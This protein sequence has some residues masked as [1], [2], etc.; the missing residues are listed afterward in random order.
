MNRLEGVI[1]KGIG[2]FYTVAVGERSYVC[3]AR[4][5][6]RRDRITPAI[7][8]RVRILPPQGEEDGFI[9]EILPRA[10]LLVR[11]PVANITRLVVALSAQ[12][13]QPDYLLADRLIVAA[14][15]AE[16]AVTI[17]FNKLDLVAEPPGEVE[18]Y[19]GCFPVLCVSSRTGQGIEELKRHLA[20][21]I[22]CFA[23]QSGVGKSSLLNAVD[24]GCRE[25]GD[26]TRIERGRN[27]TR[28]AELIPLPGGGMVVDTAGFS[29][30]E[31]AL[32]PPEELME[33]YPELAPYVGECRFQGCLHDREPGC[34]VKEAVQSGAVPRGRYE[35]Y[36][37]LLEEQRE[38]WRN[39]YD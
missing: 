32:Q 22:A 21:E 34:R 17:C 18:E 24:G 19:R 36:V 23:G 9:E 7:G 38:K 8:D 15:R 13:P 20:G 37:A 12:Y 28:H 25:T 31:M 16:I 4:G 35:R 6:F 29:L 3:R 33:R 1:V 11:P 10:N 14:R 2:G 26:L 30:Y 39:R 5:R 27:T